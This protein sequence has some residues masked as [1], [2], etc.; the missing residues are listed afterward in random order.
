MSQSAN[1]EKT[2]LLNNDITLKVIPLIL[3][4]DLLWGG[5]AVAMKV[6]L[7]YMPPLIL[8]GIR[9][10]LSAIIIWFWA[11]LKNIDIRIQKQDLTALVW[12]SIIFTAQICA[13]NIG[14]KYTTA[15][16]A[17]VLI[18]A[19][20]FLIAILAHFY[21]PEDKLSIRKSIG[22]ILAFFGIYV[23][24][25]DKIDS[26]EPHIMG[27]IIIVVSGFLFGILTIYTKKL[28]QR[29]GVYKI[30]FWE[31]VFGLAPFF[32]L[33]LIFERSAHYSVSTELIVVLIYQ[34]GIVASIAFIIWTTL[35]QRHSASKISAFLFAAPLFGI[36]LSALILH[37]TITI[38]LVIGAILVA[39]G[40][41]IVNK[42]PEPTDSSKAT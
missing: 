5:N 42:S 29:M 36:G 31:M 16:R 24:F 2:K 17:S 10:A 32:L 25:R 38:Y 14:A 13:F 33:S 37:E 18:N 22:L 34:G 11:K 39:T 3:L 4:L 9:F 21:I 30:L 27:D 35:L 40:I 8:A 12:L 41:F 26:D 1:I 23:I 7:K 20:P 15:S 19:N 28:M 6:A